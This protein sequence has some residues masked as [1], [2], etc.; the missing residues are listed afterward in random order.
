MN[1]VLMNST[2]RIARS[3]FWLVVIGIF[4]GIG[5][6]GKGAMSGSYGSIFS[7]AYH[8]YPIALV[9]SVNFFILISHKLDER[10]AV[11]PHNDRA[12]AMYHL[13]GYYKVI[14]MVV[15]YFL[16]YRFIVSGFFG[17]GFMDFTPE[18]T[19]FEPKHMGGTIHSASSAFM[20]SSQEVHSNM[21]VGMYSFLAVYFVGGVYGY[22][23]MK[24][25]ADAFVR[26]AYR[27]IM[28][29]A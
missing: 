24:T 6:F 25:K 21:F 8:W 20:L 17:V 11:N 10:C 1:K 18:S 5:L 9:L 12:N 15:A 2:D 16:L 27:G 23:W 7:D 3:F 29:R 26:D 4:S 19:L 14:M 22:Y 28:R 13:M